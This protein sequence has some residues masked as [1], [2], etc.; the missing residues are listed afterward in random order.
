[1]RLSVSVRSLKIVRTSAARGD[2]WSNLH[3][4]LLSNWMFGLTQT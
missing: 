1:M 3:V 4:P 2:S